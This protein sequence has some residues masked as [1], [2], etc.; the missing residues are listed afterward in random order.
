MRVL[1]ALCPALALLG[2][3]ALTTAAMAS[4]PAASAPVL[5][6]PQ[7]Y[8]SA[9][10]AFDPAA[11]NR[12][13]SA[14]FRL[15]GKTVAQSFGYDDSA[16]VLYTAQVDSTK[17]A[18]KQGD[19]L[20]TKICNARTSKK[21]GVIHLK[22]FGHGTS[23][24]VEPY[25]SGAARTNCG[26][27]AP[28]AYLWVEVDSAP[29]QDGRGCGRKLARILFR[30]GRSYSYA[31]GRISVTDAKGRPSPTPARVFD[32]VPGATQLAPSY[33]PTSDRL[34]LHYLRGQDW[35]YSLFDRADILDDKTPA[36][37]I[38]PLTAPA[39]SEPDRGK[40]EYFQGFAFHGAW[41]YTLVGYRDRPI[42]RITAFR[43]DGSSA[44]SATVPASLHR[45]LASRYA[46]YEPEGMALRVLADGSVRLRWGLSVGKAGISKG[47]FNRKLTIY[48]LRP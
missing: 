29:N 45:M 39:G 1:G 24:G 7:T 8:A 20:I 23:I 10:A 42:T 32:P 18:E 43:T 13:V 46:T 11:A 5:A 36:D 30:A 22:G 34:L 21:Y 44:R 9:D 48:E 4:A 41:I 33:D 6:I 25:R 3:I 27:H 38:A 17:N 19:V 47:T 16:N 31:D 14:P 28:D 37:L 2:T 40:Q 35:H 15:G 12:R 26:A